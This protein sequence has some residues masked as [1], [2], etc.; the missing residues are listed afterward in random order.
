MTNRFEDDFKYTIE[1][2]PNN[3]IYDHHSSVKQEVQNWCDDNF[4]EFCSGYYWYQPAKRGL[5]VC[6]DDFHTL[7]LFKLIWG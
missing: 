5:I 4:G 1:V 7:L 6:S 3:S 2:N